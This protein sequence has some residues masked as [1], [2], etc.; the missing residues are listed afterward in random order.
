MINACGKQ[1]QEVYI[2]KAFSRSINAPK[3]EVFTSQNW[4]LF[5]ISTFTV[6]PILLIRLWWK[7]R[8]KTAN[9]YFPGFHPW[10]IPVQWLAKWM[11]V[12]SI[13]TIHDGVFTSG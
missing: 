9:F 1:I 3:V 2:S 12:S 7:Y 4:F 13:Q 6:L 11:K 10:N 8:T 5:G